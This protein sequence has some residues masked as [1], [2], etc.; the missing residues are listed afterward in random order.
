MGK[1][2]ASEITKQYIKYVIDMLSTLNF[3]IIIQ[4][5]LVKIILHFHHRLF[6]FLFSTLESRSYNYLEIPYDFNIVASFPQNESIAL[7]DR[8]I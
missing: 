2:I 3:Q 1:N 7:I 8:R 5:W 6:Y 4:V